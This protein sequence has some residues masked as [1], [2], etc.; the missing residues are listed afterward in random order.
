MSITITITNPSA[1]ALEEVFDALA[2]MRA[3][4]HVEWSEEE[5]STFVRDHIG[6]TPAEVK[7][8]AIPTDEARRVDTLA[9]SLHRSWVTENVVMAGPCP[10]CESSVGNW[11]VASSGAAYRKYAHKARYDGW[12]AEVPGRSAYLMKAAITEAKRMVKAGE[13]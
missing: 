3:S 9:R 10:T 6:A 7:T 8:V 13:A 5:P 2:R 12:A 11:C 4:F 1:G